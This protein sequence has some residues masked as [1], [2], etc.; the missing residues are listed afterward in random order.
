MDQD[1]I[2]GNPDEITKNPD[3]INKNPEPTE[4]NLPAD[5]VDNHQNDDQNDD[6]EDD[7]DSDGDDDD[8]DDDSDSDD[9][10]TLFHAKHIYRVA[11]SKHTL[12]DLL[13][14]ILI[15]GKQGIAIYL[16]CELSN[17]LNVIFTIHSP[18]THY[19]HS[20]FTQQRIFR[21]FIHKY[22]KS[23]TWGF[24]DC[25]PK[26]KYDEF[27]VDGSI[28]LEI[29]VEI[30]TYNYIQLP[31]KW[32]SIGPILMVDQNDDGVIMSQ[33]NYEVAEKTENY[34]DLSL[35]SDH[36]LISA[37]TS[38][39][40]IITVSEGQS[41]VYLGSTHDATYQLHI[42]RV[43]NV[44]SFYLEVCC[45]Y[46]I[47]IAF[48]LKLHP[49]FGDGDGDG[50]HMFTAN[51]KHVFHKSKKWGW[52]NLTIE[53]KYMH[54]NLMIISATIQ[55]TIATKVYPSETCAICTDKRKLLLYS[56]GHMAVCVKCTNQSYNNNPSLMCPICR[57]VSKTPL[58]LGEDE[59][60]RD[61][62]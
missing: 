54:N 59:L 56:C 35:L 36:K 1:E 45:E 18:F 46:P 17:H 11:E 40:D 31:E 53:N 2:T 29:K 25:I 27:C 12:N 33:K 15:D 32:Q 8:D 7:D 16:K 10:V 41:K 20:P 52:S 24:P 26:N 3:E 37:T 34:Y 44:F 9:Y 13:S 39:R 5:I 21:S 42:R 6:Q 57:S 4:I 47:A 62:D 28:L 14:I 43:A 38:Y 22:T 50:D 51:L 30:R 19:I 49:I 48:S 60:R 61:F 58:Y 55:R 23:S